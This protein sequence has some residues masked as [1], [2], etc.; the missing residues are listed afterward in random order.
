[1]KLTRLFAG[2]LFAVTCVAT[3]AEIYSF[4]ST[5]VI[6]DF[7]PG[8]GGA[9]QFPF[10]G[11]N[12]GDSLFYH[13][14]YDINIAPSFSDGFTTRWEMDGSGSYAMLGSTRVDFDSIR[15]VVSSDGILG[16]NLGF[17]GFVDED[18]VS[19]GLNI[20]GPEPLGH[21]LPTSVN[22]SQFTWS[23]NAGA[24]SDQ[25][26]LLFPIVLGTV[27]SATITPAPAGSLLLLAS[28]AIV[29]RRR[30]V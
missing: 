6:T 18:G 4:E 27:D 19:A 16:G 20:E 1:M 5:G 17:S 10:I 22:L 13:F 26:L 28:A 15:I 14:E 24:D 21:V 12:T 3:D 8:F 29:R 23:R 11:L 2:V 7:S 9:D 25:N 30:S